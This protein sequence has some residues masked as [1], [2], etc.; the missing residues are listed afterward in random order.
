MAK[1]FKTILQKEKRKR[2][3]CLESTS[4]DRSF[5]FPFHLIDPPSS[6]IASQWSVVP[7][8]PPPALSASIYPPLAFV[9]PSPIVKVTKLF[10]T[11]RL[12]SSWTSCGISWRVSGTQQGS[13]ISFCWQATLATSHC[14]QRTLGIYLGRDPVGRKHIAPSVLP[15]LVCGAYSVSL[16]PTYSQL[17]TWIVTVSLSAT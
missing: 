15:S 16:S 3:D 6:Y 5:R 11:S 10:Q 14:H 8:A 1:I 7:L 12:W 9:R 13:V 2:E 17:T 4:R